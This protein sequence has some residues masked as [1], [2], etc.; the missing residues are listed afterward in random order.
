MIFVIFPLFGGVAIILLY[1]ARQLGEPRGWSVRSQ[2][3]MA[4]FGAVVLGALT[5]GMQSFSL[6]RFAEWSDLLLDVLGAVG[7]RA[8]L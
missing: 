3:G 7:A 6:S 4:F 2:Y 5:E 1:L 8:F